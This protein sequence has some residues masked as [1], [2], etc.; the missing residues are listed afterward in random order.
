MDKLAPIKVTSR[1]PRMLAGES[2]TTT[3]TPEIWEACTLDGRWR[4]VREDRVSTPWV[5]IF[6][7]LGRQGGTYASL[8]AARKAVALGHAEHRACEC[9]AC[10]GSGRKTE[11]RRGAEHAHSFH[12]Y[13]READGVIAY[14]HEAGPC[15]AC[16]GSGRVRPTV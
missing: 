14:A 12:A 5:A 2:G 13:R 15:E 4:F 8:P 10:E 1:T 9:L 7:P 11:W 16:A 3:T 6:L